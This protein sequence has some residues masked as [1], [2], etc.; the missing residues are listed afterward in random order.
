MGSYGRENDMKFKMKIGMEINIQLQNS[1]SYIK[2]HMEWQRRGVGWDG[3]PK[4]WEALTI[5]ITANLDGK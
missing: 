3:V 2:G 5:L 4:V 1:V